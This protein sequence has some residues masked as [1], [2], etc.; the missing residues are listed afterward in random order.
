M[1]H[2]D[3]TQRRG[4]P[5]REGGLAGPGRPV[6]G[7][8]AGACGPRLRR[9][10]GGGQRTQ[11]HGRHRGTLPPQTAGFVVRCQRPRPGSAPV[12][13][14][15]R[16]W[17]SLG[18]SHAWTAGRT[19]RDRP[20]AGPGRTAR[21]HDARRPRRSGDQGRAS[22]RRTT[23]RG[24]GARRS[25]APRTTRSR[26]TSSRATATRS[27]SSSTSSPDDGGAPR[28][29]GRAGRRAAG[30][31]P[32]RRARPARLLDGSAARAQPRLVVL[33]DQRVRPRRPGGRPARLRPDRPGRGRADVADRLRPDDQQ[34]VGVPIGDLL[35]GMYGA[36][37]VARRAARARAHR[38][39][40]AWSAPRCSPRSSACTPSRAPAGRSPGRCR[41]PRATTTLRSP[42]WAVPLPGRRGAALGRQRGPVA[43]V[44]RRLRA[45][46]RRPRG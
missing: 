20:D 41:R 43:A 26:R 23:T 14:P 45:G 7:H 2:R 38:P 36:Y 18:C 5:A 8:H 15:A 37:G 34:R 12:A 10:Y 31:L 24:T 42:L 19:R 33:L 22:G 40:A 11:R 25:S 16:A 3:A 13:V 32:H 28:A 44:L 27:R 29:A 17:R 30:E 6:D 9:P 35:A 1:Q 39:R 21:R 46:P 4:Q